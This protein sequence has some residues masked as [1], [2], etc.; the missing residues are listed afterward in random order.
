MVG[1]FIS[2][3]ALLIL[4]SQIKVVLG[5][6]VSATDNWGQVVSIVEQLPL[7]HVSTLALGGIGFIVLLGSRYFLAPW[8]VQRGMASTV[9]PW[10]CV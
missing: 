10:P 3:S 7:A 2:G 9:P 6:Q 1:G 8:L 4:L 5:I